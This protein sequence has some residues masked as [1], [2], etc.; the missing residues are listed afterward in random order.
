MPLA[1]G[2]GLGFAGR[3]VVRPAQ[4]LLPPTEGNSGRRRTLAPRAKRRRWRNIALSKPGLPPSLVFSGLAAALLLTA[5][6]PDPD[7]APSTGDE[8]KDR[9][10]EAQTARK[11]TGAEIQDRTLNRVVHTVYLCDNGERL[12]VDFDNPRQMA[13][14]RNSS[15][16]AVDLYQERAA[17]GIWYRASNVELRGKGVLATW[18]VEGR[19]PTQCRAV[20]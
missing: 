12:S 17:D 8:V 4:V 1:P 10:I 3:R 11:R 16:E 14:I 19:Q 15:G 20:D 13:T 18:S 7:T 2:D 5:C 6:G 9:A